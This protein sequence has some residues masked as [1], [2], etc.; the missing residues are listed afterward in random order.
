[1]LRHSHMLKVIQENTLSFMLE[2]S[3]LFACVTTN[4]Q[5]WCVR[6]K[7]ADS[8]CRTNAAGTWPVCPAGARHE[9]PDYSSSHKQMESGMRAFG[10]AWSIRAVGPQ[11][12]CCPEISQADPPGARSVLPLGSRCFPQ[13]NL[14]LSIA[15]FNWY[16]FYPSVLL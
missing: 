5:Q 16:A 3:I 10:W 15:G 13:P 1:M 7:G 11:L 6:S 2:N 12:S 14:P 8:S 9:Q 4:R